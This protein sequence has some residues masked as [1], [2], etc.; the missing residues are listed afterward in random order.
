MF[1]RSERLSEIGLDIPQVT[2]LMLTLQE[3]GIDVDGGIYT[4]DQALERLTKIL[5]K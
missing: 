1:S 2:K 3:N 4:V 5:K